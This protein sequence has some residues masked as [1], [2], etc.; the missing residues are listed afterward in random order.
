MLC[1]YWITLFPGFTMA[2]HWLSPFSCACLYTTSRHSTR[3]IGKEKLVRH[4]CLSGGFVVLE[5]ESCDNCSMQVE[6]NFTNS[7]VQATAQKQGQLWG[8]AGLLRALLSCGQALWIPHPSRTPSECGISLKNSYAQSSR[9]RWVFKNLYFR[10][11]GLCITS[12]RL[13]PSPHSGS[14]Q[15]VL[16]KNWK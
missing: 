10:L 12:L 2:Q 14:P 4:L 3:S 13:I 5:F 9:D 8:Q 15:W 11:S 16:I 7:L 6:Q 1:M